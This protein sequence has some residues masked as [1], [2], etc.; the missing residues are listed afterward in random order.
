[1]ESLKSENFAERERAAADLLVWARERLEGAT[2]LLYQRS[3]TDPEPEVRERCLAVLRELLSDDYQ[4]NGVGFVGIRMNPNTEMVN[5]ADDPK[6]RF[7]IRIIQVEAETPAQKSGLVAGD[8]LL[9]VNDTFWQQEHTSDVVMAKIKT[10]KA[11]TKV[12]IKLA[13]EGK[14]VDV[15]MVLARRP[16]SA[17]FLPFRLGMPITPEETLAIERTA[18]EEHFRRWLAERKSRD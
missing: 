12:S 15:P 18:R 13:R 1:M 11:G 4:R 3:R 7:A 6:P 14:I 8:L 9:G 10:F 5:L 2:E 16:A 17:D